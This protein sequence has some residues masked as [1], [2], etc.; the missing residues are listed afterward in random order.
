MLREQTRMN[1]L[2][3]KVTLG[4]GEVPLVVL[5]LGVSVLLALQEAIPAILAFLALKRIP[6]AHRRQR[7]GLAFLLLIPL[8][9]LVWAFFVHPKV[10]ESLKRWYAAQGNYSVGD[11]GRSLAFCLCICQVGALIPR[12]GMFAGV[13]WLVLLVTFYVKAFNLSGRIPKAA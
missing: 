11:C 3:R 13:A 1:L 7:A 8:F 2:T 12:L 10:A 4:F 6:I 5:V 9:S